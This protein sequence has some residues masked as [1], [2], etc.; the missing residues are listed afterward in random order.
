MTLQCSMRLSNLFCDCFNFKCTKQGM[1]GE[2]LY[3]YIL[4]TVKCKGQE[5]ELIK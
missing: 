4:V 1:L 3:F 2:G 5:N